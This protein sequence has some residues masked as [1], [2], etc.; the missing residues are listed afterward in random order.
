MRL[1][2]FLIGLHEVDSLPLVHNRPELAPQPNDMSSSFIWSLKLVDLTSISKTG[3]YFENDIAL[4][5][6][7]PFK[8][9]SSI[10]PLL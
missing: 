9:P 7:A 2:V 1:F 5:H 6:C 4:T 3:T 10:L 8:S